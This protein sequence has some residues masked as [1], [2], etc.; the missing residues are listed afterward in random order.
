MKFTPPTPGDL[1]ED[2]DIYRRLAGDLDLLA[3]GWRPDDAA[4]AAAPVLMLA[5]FSSRPEACLTGFRVG[6]HPKLGDAGPGRMC[7][8]SGIITMSADDG[9][10]RTIS[11]WWRIELGDK[12]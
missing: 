3:T 9:W 2:A 12:P 4:L 6:G 11:R 10:A 5:R 7:V 8:T 1:A